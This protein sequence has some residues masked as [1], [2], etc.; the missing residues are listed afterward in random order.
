MLVRFGHHRFLAGHAGV[1]RRA[2]LF[3]SAASLAR[4]NHS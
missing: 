4:R 3:V 2:Y 1:G